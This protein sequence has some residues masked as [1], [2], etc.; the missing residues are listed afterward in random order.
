[1]KKLLSVTALLCVMLAIFGC[2][3]P[4]PEPEVF[5][6]LTFSL[7]MPSGQTLQC[8]V[9]QDAKTIVNS[10]DPVEPGLPASQYIMKINYTATVDT[11]IKLDG[12]SIESGVTTADFSAPVT[13]VAV[14]GDKEI[15]YT[16]TVIED[17]NDASL[18]SGK[19]VNSDMTGSGFPAAAWFDVA[20]FKGEFFAITSSYPE[21]TADEN[22]AN[23]E[24]Y[25][26]ADGIAWTKVETNIPVV[27]A[28][29]ARLA[30]F[31]D[32]LW[33]FGGGYLYGSDANGI[34][35]E[36]MWGMAGFFDIGAFYIFSSPD[37]ENW[38]QETAVDESEVVSGYVDSRILNINNKLNYFG[39]MATV[40]GSMQKTY[41]VASSTDGFTWTPVGEVDRASAAATIGCGAMYA[42]K[43]T[44][45][46]A[47]GF[48]N[49]VSPG[50]GQTAVY[51]STDGGLTWTE[52]TADGGFGAMWNMRVIGTDDVL[53]M[54][55]G[56]YYENGEPDA[57]G[58]STQSLTTSNKIYR[59]TDGVN[60][61]A[62]DGENALPDTY[63]GRS[64]PCLVADGDMLW[65]FGGRGNCTGYYG[66]PS[67]EDQII[68]DTWK[69][70]IK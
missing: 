29:G 54:V 10:S 15:S 69:K 48:K 22:P 7:T 14:K 13:I 60:W 11:D 42:F 66:G 9:D 39:G 49:F 25:K 59:S 45:Y 27:G 67:A 50:Y 6:V 8:V 4:E 33:S 63:V 3:K 24:V 2:D 32:K 44:L 35:P 31:N 64:R 23:Y 18:T 26:S 53:Y 16:V 65:I 52:A 41:N 1:M 21:G 12:A 40:F 38:T 56:E 47:G 19:R 61:T 58:N 5:G 36:L 57:E 43:G 68:F 51:S 28:F 30:V 17:A 37:G 46:L 70:K 55:G 20:F 62:L 34:G